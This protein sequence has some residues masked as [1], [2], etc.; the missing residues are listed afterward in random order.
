M[1]GF[2]Q[3]RRPHSV[4]ALDD[5]VCGEHSASAVL[6]PFKIDF[7]GAKNNAEKEVPGLSRC[8]W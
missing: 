7:E 3:S 1:G 6:S 5:G 8:I 4:A 2:D